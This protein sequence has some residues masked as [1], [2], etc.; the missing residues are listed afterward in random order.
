M[1][2]R[3][4]HAAA[5][6]AGWAKAAEKA[7]SQPGVGTPA[8]AV[9]A[10]HPAEKAARMASLA[11]ADRATKETQAAQSAMSGAVGRRVAWSF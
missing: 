6:T 5:E 10:V 9:A 4:A 2:R 7:G 8:G 11:G 3:C 1:A